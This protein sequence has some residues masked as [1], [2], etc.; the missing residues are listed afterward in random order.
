MSTFKRIIGFDLGTSS[1]TKNAAWSHDGELLIPSIAQIGREATNILQL[2][3]EFV[4]ANKAL[5]GSGAL[6]PAQKTALQLFYLLNLGDVVMEAAGPGSSGLEVRDVTRLI[7]LAPHNLYVISGRVVKN[8][9]K[10][11]REEYQPIGPRVEN[12][13]DAARIIWE[14]A[15]TKPD[16][17]GLWRGPTVRREFKYRSVRPYDKR[18]YRDPVVFEKLAT[19]PAVEK[20]PP[21]LHFLLTKNGKYNPADALPIAMSFEEDGAR[22]V[23]FWTDYILGGFGRGPKS[24][25]RRKVQSEI[26]MDLAKKLHEDS[27]KRGSG[28]R[29]QALNSDISPETR[30]EA[31]RIL[32]REL[33]ELHWLYYNS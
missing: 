22:S 17:I 27:G 8:Y 19:L 24:F 14:V 26:T 2:K 31:Q 20:L 29:G 1:P 11:H 4:T 33:K 6:T 25:Y 10:D 32:G 15:T 9:R 16:S 7:E 18:A 28:A 5:D 30:K 3:D 12:D 21:H 13:L 23:K